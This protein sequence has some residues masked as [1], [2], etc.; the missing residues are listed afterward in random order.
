MRGR[1]CSMLVRHSFV[2]FYCTLWATLRDVPAQSRSLGVVGPEDLLVDGPP[3]EAGEVGNY[4]GEPIQH[5]DRVRLKD[6]K[7]AR[8]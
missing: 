6:G 3:F 7:P 2:G 4:I 1:R 8:Q 5:P